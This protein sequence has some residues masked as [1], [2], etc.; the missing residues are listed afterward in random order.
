MEAKASYKLWFP[1]AKIVTKVGTLRVEG[2]RVYST[3]Q[4]FGSRLGAKMLEASEFEDAVA[5]RAAKRAAISLGVEKALRKWR[6]Q[7][8]TCYRVH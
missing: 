6:L 1:F 5:G 7:M 4:E 3:K 2:E 8:P